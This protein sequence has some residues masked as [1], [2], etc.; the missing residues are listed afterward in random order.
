MIDAPA[1]TYTRFPCVV[2]HDQR[3]KLPYGFRG[4]RSDKAEG[5]GPLLVDVRAA[6]LETG[7]YTLDE[8]AHRC[9]IERKS[10]EDLYC[11]LGQ[12]RERF[13]HEL[14]RL[15]LLEWA[16]VMIEAPWEA[17]RYRPPGFSQLNPKT[18]GR[19]IDAWMMRFPRVHWV[20]EQDRR[21]AEARTFQLLR[22][23]WKD[24]QK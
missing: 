9:A 10:L 22:R 13:E 18:V 15:N 12:H 23:F 19:S 16:C 17:I 7:D 1:P 20:T 3:E 2:L 5:G 6:H 11:T 4:L 8:Y 14:Y 24:D 21:H